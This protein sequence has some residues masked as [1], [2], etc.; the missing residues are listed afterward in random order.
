MSLDQARGVILGLA[1]G[2]AVGRP[3]EGLGPDEIQEEYGTITGMIG[4]GQFNAPAGKTTD[5]TAL[6]YRL[7]KSLIEQ[8]GFDPGDYAVRLVEWYQKD[9]FGYGQTTKESILHLMDGLSWHEAGVETWKNAQIGYGAGNGSVMRCA[10]L[11]LAFHTHDDA[12]V[13]LDTTSMAS[14]FV[15]HAD[16]RCVY[17]CVILNRIIANRLSD[18]TTNPI[19]DVFRDQVGIHSNSEELPSEFERLSDLPIIPTKNTFGLTPYVI[20]SLEISLQHG[21]TASSTADAIIGAVNEGGDTD[22]VGAMA[23]A[24]AGAKHGASSL[25]DRWLDKLENAE[26]LRTIAERLYNHTSFDGATPDDFPPLDVRSLKDT[27]PQCGRDLSEATGSS[28][29]PEC[30][31]EIH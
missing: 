24:I 30:G 10:P 19:E 4:G 22:T 13:S 17:G 12:G 23:G 7:A 5:D 31:K 16:P 15:T 2:D 3:V 1:C 11:T 20:D 28:Y 6:A 27:C 29:C 14:S 25:P 26:E 8:N 21:L 9:G 18:G